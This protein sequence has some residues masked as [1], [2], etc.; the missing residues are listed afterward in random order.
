MPQ[1]CKLW[2]MQPD[3]ATSIPPLQYMNRTAGRTSLA[4]FT[5]PPMLS[6]NHQ[7]SPSRCKK[8]ARKRITHTGRTSIVQAGNLNDYTL[9]SFNMMSTSLQRMGP[10]PTHSS[11]P[12]P[13]HTH[14]HMQEIQ[15]ITLMISPERPHLPA[16]SPTSVHGMSLVCI[17]TCHGLTSALEDCVICA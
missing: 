8:L 9:L 11:P 14:T 12:T 17:I 3:G 13:T 7:Y 5:K 4:A 6:Q 10:L 1:G 2:A 16:P 15:V